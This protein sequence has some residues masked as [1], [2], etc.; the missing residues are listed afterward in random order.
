MG[1]KETILDEVDMFDV[2]AEFGFSML[3]RSRQRYNTFVKGDTKIIV[4]NE[5]SKPQ[6]YFNSNQDPNDKGDIIA[7]VKYHKDQNETNYPD[8][9]KYLSGFTS[10]STTPRPNVQS[11]IQREIAQEADG[12]QEFDVNKFTLRD[13][14][15]SRLMDKKGL[16]GVSSAEAFKGTVLMARHLSGRG[17]KNLFGGFE[18]LAFLLKRL[19]TGEIKGMEYRF[20]GEKSMKRQ[21]PGSMKSETFWISN[22]A[23]GSEDIFLCESPIDAMSHYAMY[24]KNTAQHP[25]VQYLST[26]GTVTDEQ[27]RQIMATSKGRIFMGFDNDFAG[28]GYTIKL[29]SA[30]SNGK[31]IFERKKDEIVVD[32]T[33]LNLDSQFILT[34]GAASLPGQYGKLMAAVSACGLF[35]RLIDAKA[36]NKDFNDDLASGVPCVYEFDKTIGSIE[37]LRYFVGEE[38]HVVKKK[39]FISDTTDSLIKNNLKMENETKFSR[40]DVSGILARYGTKISDLNKIQVDGLMHGYGVLVNGLKSL[41]ADSKKP[42][43]DAR[44]RLS[45]SG[46]DENRIVDS[47]L[48]FKADKLVVYSQ[49]FGH[50]IDDKMEKELKE[51]GFLTLYNCVREK[52]GEQLGTVVVAVDPELNKLQYGTMAKVNIPKKLKGVDLNDEQRLELKNGKEINL[53]LFDKEVGVRFNPVV[54]SFSFMD[55]ERK[56]KY[57]E[58]LKKVPTASKEEVAEIE[59][60]ILA[61]RQ[62][63]GQDKSPLLQTSQKQARATE[64][65]DNNVDQKQKEKTKKGQGL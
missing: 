36:K 65:V 27:I 62:A 35:P 13:H 39:D 57:R 28:Y 63:A 29:L 60:K 24:V 34:K 45:A 41:R 7:L 49:M 53:H 42:Q 50:K 40:E 18:N 32:G 48:D 31:L 59:A 54:S 22:K 1:R 52:T 61:N 56:E 12:L 30:F 43:F 21:A 23:E 10:L 17:E 4:H 19:D 6:F 51:T 2:L 46:K 5:S 25:A 33:F 9:L 47:K 20:D 64:H 16:H 38:A 37:N 26:S 44:I 58:D 11:R 55:A 8:V 15:D 14:I 3:E